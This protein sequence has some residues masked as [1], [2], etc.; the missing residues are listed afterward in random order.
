MDDRLEN[1][2]AE[3]E[4]PA[5]PPDT[6]VRRPWHR[7]EVKAVGLVDD[8]EIGGVVINDGAVFS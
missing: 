1:D 3:D 6:P 4:A 7:P 2:H 8:T 5:Q